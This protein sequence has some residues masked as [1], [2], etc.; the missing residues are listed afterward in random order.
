MKEDIIPEGPYCYTLKE[1]T[2]RTSDPYD[3]GVEYLYCPYYTKL[4]IGEI[5]IPYCLFS[6]EGDLGNINNKQWEKLK[7]RFG[8]DD[9]G[10]F[11]MFPY[12]LLWD[13]C[14]EC[15]VNWDDDND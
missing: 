7:E 1:R 2:E 15:G 5:K 13:H 6:K 12:S 11:E 14:K 8:V 10:L 3:L 9:D 4:C